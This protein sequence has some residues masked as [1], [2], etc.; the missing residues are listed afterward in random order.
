VASRDYKTTRAAAPPARSGSPML[1]G[2]VIGILIGLGVALA[3]AIYLFK[4]PAPFLPKD[5]PGGKP[6]VDGSTQPGTPAIDAPGKSGAS[7]PGS[8]SAP[9]ATASEKQRFDFY[10]IL[11]GTEETVKDKKDPKRGEAV[12]PDGK[13]AVVPV[14]MYFLQ[15]G[16]FQSAADADD[17][18]ARLALAGHEARIQTAD[19]PEGKLL[20]RVRVGPFPSVDEARRV[21]E[22]LKQNQI[23][24]TLVKVK[25]VPE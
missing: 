21:R 25:A 6:A 23:D 13:A 24:A 9:A 7:K 4:V 17:L 8:P 20:H 14:D 15:A 16:A 3:V 10:K 22:Q 2:I 5:E 11:P 19:L 12:G 1:V 18:K